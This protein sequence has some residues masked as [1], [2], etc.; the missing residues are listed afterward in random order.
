MLIYCSTHLSIVAFMKIVAIFIQLYYLSYFAFIFSFILTAIVH[1]SIQATI[2]HPARE[3]V[4]ILIIANSKKLLI[5]INTDSWIGHKVKI[6]DTLRMADTNNA[7]KMK[8]SI[9]GFFRKLRIWSHLL[10]KSLMENFIFLCSV[11]SWKT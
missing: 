2:F 7:P 8:F 4:N 5:V 6:D 11:L 9:K 3:T 10:K 1:L